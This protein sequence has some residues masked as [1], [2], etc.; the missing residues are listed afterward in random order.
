MLARRKITRVVE[1][2]A[3]EENSAVN[4]EHVIRGFITSTAK[5]TRSRQKQ[6][7]IDE[8]INPDDYKE[9]FDYE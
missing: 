8:G 7:L 9:D 2:L 6:P 4:R 1:Q 3:N 5:V